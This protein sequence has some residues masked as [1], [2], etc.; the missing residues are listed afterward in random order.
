[1]H[2]AIGLGRTKPTVHEILAELNNVDLDWYLLGVGLKVPLDVLDQFNKSCGGHITKCK[3]KVVDHWLTFSPNYDA[4][5]EM[6]V[7]TL[8]RTGCVGVGKRLYEKYRQ[9]PTFRKT[10]HFIIA[11]YLLLI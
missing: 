6:V 3:R 11:L 7:I 10:F 9:F 1:M 2:H 8:R 5:W 4:T